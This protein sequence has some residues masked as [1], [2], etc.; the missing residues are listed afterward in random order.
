MLKMNGTGGAFNPSYT[1]ANLLSWV[2]AGFVPQNAALKGAG[3]GGADVGALAVVP[4][5]PKQRRV[6]LSLQ[7]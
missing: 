7:L 2:R 3:F 5:I 6:A 1:V 4:R